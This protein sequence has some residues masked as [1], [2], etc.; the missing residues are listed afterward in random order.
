MTPQLN[1]DVGQD[2]RMAIKE[3]AL[4]RNMTLREHVID[5]LEKDLEAGKQPK[6]DAFKGVS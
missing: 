6:L 5:V 1:V 3:K 4:H 2:L